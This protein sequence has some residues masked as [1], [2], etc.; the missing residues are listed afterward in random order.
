LKVE[1]VSGDTYARIADGDSIYDGWGANQGFVTTKEGAVVVDTGFTAGAARALIDEVKKKSPAPAR[2]VVNTHD[3]SDHVFGNSL[4]D[5]LSPIIMAHANCRSRLIEMGK[6]RMNGYRRFDPRLK[7]ALKGLRICP[8]RLTFQEEMDFML[9][10]KRIRLLH[11]RKT[12]HTTG[13]T[14][15][16]L[17][18]ERV[19][20]AGDVL[21]V[22]YH[23]N[24]ED[25][26]IEGWLSALEG[27]SKMR[28]DYIVPGHGPVTDKTSIAPLARYIRDFDAVFSK[29]VR[30]GLSKERIVEELVME[31]TEEWLLS[32]IV[33]RNV[34]VLY[35]RYRKRIKEA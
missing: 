20:F 9:G 18:D 10:E 14:M 27:I 32:M 16:F 35:E 15:V 22:R 31:G 33:E 29:L 25:A 28:V 1:R 3:H 19:L 4:F 30:D 8:P 5:E 17:P 11:P 6:E 21:W 12:A 2:L 34:G 24:L 7:S 26:D 23:P 13:D